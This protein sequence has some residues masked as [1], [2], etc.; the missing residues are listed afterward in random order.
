MESGLFSFTPGTVLQEKKLVNI[1]KNMIKYPIMSAFVFIYYF[2][3][4]VDVGLIVGYG[5]PL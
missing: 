5:V 1:E 3:G 2:F 4:W